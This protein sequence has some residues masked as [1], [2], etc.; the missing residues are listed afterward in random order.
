MSNASHRTTRLNKLFAP[1]TKTF[2]DVQVFHNALDFLSQKWSHQFELGKLEGSRTIR[3][4]D[5]VLFEYTMTHIKVFMQ[6]S[7]NH[8]YEYERIFLLNLIRFCGIEYER[9]KIAA[10]NYDI[11]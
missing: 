11:K 6:H 1:T 4:R 5:G 2:Y 3:K 10:I 8:F 7:E 9:L